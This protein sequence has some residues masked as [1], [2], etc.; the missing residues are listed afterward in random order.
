M[1]MKD[2]L[3]SCDAF[4]AFAHA[5]C[6]VASCWWSQLCR[7]NR[8]KKEDVVVSLKRLEKTVEKKLAG[9]YKQP[10]G[11]KGFKK[12][13]DCSGGPPKVRCLVDSL[14]NSSCL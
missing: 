13:Q 11:K 9:V 2:P 8:S 1:M 3:S 14:V 7:L 10:R 5:V 6:Y 12:G 4:Q